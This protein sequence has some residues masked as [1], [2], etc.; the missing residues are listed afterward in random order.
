MA[1]H[2][3]YDARLDGTNGTILYWE[4]FTD[5]SERELQNSYKTADTDLYTGLDP[6]SGDATERQRR[7]NLD[8][9][10]LDANLIE[11]ELYIDNIIAQVKANAI[12]ADT[13]ILIGLFEVWQADHETTDLPLLYHFYPKV[14]TFAD[15]YVA[16]K[17]RD[18]NKK[19]APTAEER[20]DENWVVDEQMRLFTIPGRPPYKTAI[21]FLN[22]QE[23]VHEQFNKN[24]RPATNPEPSYPWEVRIGLTRFIVPP[25]SINISQNFKVGSLTGSA[26]RQQ[27]PPKFNSGHSET[28]IAMTIYFPNQES[29]FGTSVDG[30]SIANLSDPG[31]ER[32]I[33][34][35]A[36]DNDHEVDTFLSSLRGLIAQF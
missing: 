31:V 4:V 6:K 9:K 7:K 11:L 19:I 10:I 24:L 32:K 15:L 30:T 12:K 13:L 26:L 1:K 17:V 22:T 20:A 27:T 21:G 18:N 33:D 14:K 5:G 25:I 29:I 16:K 3:Y 8:E 34:F 36:K 28:T 35:D 23:R 2:Q